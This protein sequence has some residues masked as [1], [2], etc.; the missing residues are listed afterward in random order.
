MMMPC[1]RL[2]LRLRGHTVKHAVVD[3]SRP[4]DPL[5]RPA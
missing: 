2:K 3:I 5:R 1:M 4:R